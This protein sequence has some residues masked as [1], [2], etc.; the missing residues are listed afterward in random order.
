MSEIYSN[1]IGPRDAPTVRSRLLPLIH[2]HHR[3]ERRP[4]DR[5]RL[6]KALVDRYVSEDQ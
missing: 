6:G 1:E 3:F 2:P 4:T 5:R